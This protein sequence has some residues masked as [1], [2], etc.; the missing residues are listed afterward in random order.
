M[1]QDYRTFTVKDQPSNGNH[2]VSVMH[3]DDGPFF[4][5]IVNQEIVRSLDLARQ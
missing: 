5:Q 3:V 1:D 4:L 2:K